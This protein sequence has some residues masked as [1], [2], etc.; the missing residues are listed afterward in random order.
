MD[1]PSSPLTPAG[2]GACRLCGT[3]DRLSMYVCVCVCVWDVVVFVYVCIGD[4]GVCAWDVFVY[5]CM[6]W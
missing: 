3:A 5:L 1:S 2:A 4:N 6:Y